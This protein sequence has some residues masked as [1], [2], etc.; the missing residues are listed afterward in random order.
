MRVVGVLGFIFVFLTGCATPVIN[1]R[2]PDGR[3]AQCGKSY[4]WGYTGNISSVEQD[5]AC[6][7]D[8]QR[9]GFERVP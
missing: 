2:H 8:Y 5:R 9:Q 4:H 1:L 6:V 7:S 3:I